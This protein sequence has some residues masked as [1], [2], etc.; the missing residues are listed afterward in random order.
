MEDLETLDR[1]KNDLKEWLAQAWHH[2]ANSSLTTFE[3]R[4]LRNEMTACSDELRGCLQL[5]EAERARSRKSSSEERASLGFGTLNFRL[6]GQTQRDLGLAFEEQT[7]APP[8]F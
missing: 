5:I 2:V 4:E 6:I 3:R 7:S 8:C 1:K